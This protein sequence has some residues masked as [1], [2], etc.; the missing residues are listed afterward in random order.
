[1]TKTQ[2]VDRVARRLGDTSTAF[3]TILLELFDDVI[4]ELSAAEVLEPL[5][6]LAT[7]TVVEDQRTYQTATI[8]GLSSP[9]SPLRV[10]RLTVPTWGWSA[11]V[12]QAESNREFE[13]YRFGSSDD[14]RGQWRMWR[15]YPNDETLEVWP[16]AGPD[17]DGDEAEMLYLVPPASLG[18]SAEITYLRPDDLP[19]L[20][21]GL[22]MYAAPFLDEALAEVQAATE[23]FEQGKARMWARRHNSGPQRI[24]VDPAEC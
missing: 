24:A 7:F 9:N 17:Q 6:A 15:L 18:N 14:H 20:A 13:N 12:E 23:H 3:Q 4:R 2:L 11:P 22:I 21:W 19:T 5:Q 8:A 10:L 16:P 1:M